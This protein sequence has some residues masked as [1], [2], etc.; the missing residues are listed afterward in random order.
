MCTVDFHFD[1]VRLL[2]AFVFIIM[3]FMMVFQ[4]VWRFLCGAIWFFIHTAFG[5]WP[6][7]AGSFCIHGHYFYYS[8]SPKCV[9]EFISIDSDRVR[10]FI[11][12]I[13]YSWPLIFR[14]KAYFIHP[15][16]IFIR[17]KG[18]KPRRVNHLKWNPAFLFC[19]IRN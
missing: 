18:V 17:C 14:R 12:V 4:H 5:G 16:F 6:A 10:V 3:W 2:N 11:Y 15:Y 19:R 8:L 9:L 1:V 7:K 13:Y